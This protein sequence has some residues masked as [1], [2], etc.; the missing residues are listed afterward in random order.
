MRRAPCGMRF[1]GTLRGI[2]VIG[3]SRLAGFAGIK[4][5]LSPK[6]TPELLI[7]NLPASTHQR[8]RASTHVSVMHF[9]NTVIVF[10]ICLLT[11]DSGLVIITFKN[12]C[13]ERK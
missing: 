8:I 6:A 9:M 10:Q 7:A 1:R 4:Q 3:A 2:F 13:G 11:K 5:E 12:K